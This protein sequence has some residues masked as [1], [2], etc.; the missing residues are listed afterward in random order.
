[1]PVQFR[2]RAA[3]SAGRVVEGQIASAS[4]SEAIEDLRRRRLFPFDISE[5][6]RP[7]TDAAE[8][9]ESLASSLAVWTRT[10]ATMLS[11]G[12]PLETALAFASSES[13]NHALAAAVASV[14]KDI[15]DGSAFSA[16]LKKHPRVFSPLYVAMVI[17]GEETGALDTV[18]TRLADNLDET[19]ELRGRVRSAL[20]YPALLGAVASVGVI[21][22]LLL[23][24]PR[25]VGI[26]GETGGSLPLS[27]RVLVGLSNLLVAGWWVWISVGVLVI[28]GVR[29]AMASTENRE[30]WHDARLQLPLA[31]RLE[32][33]L[34]TSRFSRT[35]GLLQRSGIGMMPALRIA[36]SGVSNAALR[37]RI[38]RATERVGQGKRL[39]AELSGVLPALAVQLISVGEETGR[40][41]EMCMR[42][43]E[44]SDREVARRMR[45]LVA[46]L[47]PSLIVVFGILVGFVALAML[48]AIYSVNAYTL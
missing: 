35:L 9:R 30:R 7:V 8:R 27:T 6:A 25:F 39:G 17:A 14:R 34:Q 41:D 2:Y 44:T 31:G 12:V 18:M 21:V 46:L 15:R 11:A 38:E 22:I 33:D 32:I 47:E 3:D 23:V 42:V 28:Y 48:Q 20:L 40:V 29:R 4:R 5:S 13:G 37:R 10:A 43:A 1:M 24:V 16:A 26:L 45:S 36:A 19:E